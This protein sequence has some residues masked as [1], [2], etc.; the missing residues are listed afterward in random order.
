MYT[1]RN[2]RK[3]GGSTGRVLKLFFTR[4]KKKKIIKV[5]VLFPPVVHVVY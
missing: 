1:E 2:V 4:L 3:S 5:S